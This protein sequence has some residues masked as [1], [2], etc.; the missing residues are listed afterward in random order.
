MHKIPRAL[1]L[2]SHFKKTI[3]KKRKQI[4]HHKN[5]LVKT[6]NKKDASREV[7]IIAS[8]KT[9]TFL[10]LKDSNKRYQKIK[11]IYL[12]ISQYTTVLF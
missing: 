5:S 2:C 8:F 3:C 11:L 12:E 1:S 7:K 6:Q 9:I 4:L 10:K